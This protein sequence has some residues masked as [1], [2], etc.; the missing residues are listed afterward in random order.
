[1]TPEPAVP[2]AG[3]PEPVP[4]PGTDTTRPGAGRALPGAGAAPPGAGTAPPGAKAVPPGVGACS[5]GADPRAAGP[6][7]AA[8]RSRRSSLRAAA[9]RVDRATPSHRDRAV[10]AL[11]AAAMLG[12]VLGHWLVTALVPPG[13]HVAGRAG[14]GASWH[15]MSPLASMPGLAPVSWLFQTLA[16][17]FF[18]GGYA[19]ARSLHRPSRSPGD[20]ALP[21]VRAR[22]ARLFRPVFALPLVWAPPALVLAATGSDPRLLV[23]LAVNPLWFLCVY[24]GLT[25]LTPALDRLLARRPTIG[26]AAGRPALYAA[27][28]AAAVVAGTDLVRLGLGGPAWLGWV[29]VP[30]GCFIDYIID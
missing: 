29:N 28:V 26:P 16:V 19:A 12:V 21:W 10:D 5:P 23:R 22:M 17:F 25:A 11:R 18:V 7:R 2:A 6:H 13:P 1:M 30:V 4:R 14:G 9:E 20:A 24:A 15:D 27:G 8:R 3:D